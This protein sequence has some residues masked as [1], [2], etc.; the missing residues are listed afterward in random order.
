MATDSGHVK[1][2]NPASVIDRS[3]TPG[4]RRFEGVGD[5]G[6]HPNAPR[7]RAALSEDRICVVCM[8]RTHPGEVHGNRPRQETERDQETS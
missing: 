3:G 7:T 1:P 8:M 6:A 5:G 4:G 2:R